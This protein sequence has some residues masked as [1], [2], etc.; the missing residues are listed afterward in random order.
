MKNIIF[1]I[2]SQDQKR[3]EIQTEQLL[4][5]TLQAFQLSYATHLLEACLELRQ[6]QEALG[7]EFTKTTEIDTHMT[8]TNRFRFRSPINHM[9]IRI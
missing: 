4:F 1:P 5:A 7:H 2:E 3:I 6:I 8:N 9:D